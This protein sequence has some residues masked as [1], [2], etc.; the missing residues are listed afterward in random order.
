LSGA[1]A[2]DFA[3]FC[4]GIEILNQSGHL[5]SA[6]L[7]QLKSLYL[8]MNSNRT[9]SVRELHYPDGESLCRR[10]LPLGWIDLNLLLRDPTKSN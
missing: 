10:G 4:K 1:K 8:S 7:A 2:L 9:H 5:T 6:G 3:D